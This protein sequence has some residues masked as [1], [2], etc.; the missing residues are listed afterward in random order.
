MVAIDITGPS[1]EIEKLL[2][3]TAQQ[4]GLE[5]VSE[6]S[7]LDASKALNIGLP[8]DP[9]AALQFLTLIFTTGTAALEFFQAVRKSLKERGGTVAVS[10]STSGKKLGTLSAHSSDSELQQIVA[11]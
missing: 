6:V 2:P 11:A 7:D 8:V 10:N 1:E 5:E 4:S 9:T 3:L